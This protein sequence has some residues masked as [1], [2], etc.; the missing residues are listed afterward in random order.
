MNEINNP[1]LFKKLLSLIKGRDGELTH[2]NRIKNIDISK[3][4][5][6]CDSKLF[7]PDI[8]KYD[9]EMIDISSN[10]IVV[11]DEFSKEAKHSQPK[12]LF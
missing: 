2:N 7:L 10:D 1:L 9:A 4:K 5:L 12:L 3:N 11:S 6:K 8:P